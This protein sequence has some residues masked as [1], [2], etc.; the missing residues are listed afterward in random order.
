MVINNL[1]L[2]GLHLTSIEI[3]PYTPHMFPSIIGSNSVT[4]TRATRIDLLISYYAWL[5]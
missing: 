5:I 1:I 2:I 3:H 4:L